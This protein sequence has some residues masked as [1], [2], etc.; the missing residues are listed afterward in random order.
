MARQ[1]GRDIGRAQALGLE[2]TDLLVDG[3][4][5]G[6]LFVAEHRAI[7]G[8]WNMVEFELGGRAGI[9]QGIELVTFRNANGLAVGHGKL[10]M[11]AP[12]AA[13]QS[14]AAGR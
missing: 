14:L 3:A 13:S 1:I 6:P 8:T 10:S 4:D 12:M 11:A 5:L 2:R 7:D 9:D